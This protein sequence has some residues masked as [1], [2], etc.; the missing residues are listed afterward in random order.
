MLTR[1][2]TIRNS[3]EKAKWQLSSCE[4]VPF[5]VVEDDPLTDRDEGVE[6]ESLL[7]E[8]P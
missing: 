2:S 8:E 6:A 3:G 4:P 7:V 5:V 1:L